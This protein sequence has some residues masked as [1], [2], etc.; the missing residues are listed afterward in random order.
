MPT[1]FGI[2][3][4]LIKRLSPSGVVRSGRRTEDIAFFERSLS[5]PKLLFI[6]SCLRAAVTLA[7]PAKISIMRYSSKLAPLVAINDAL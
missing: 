7:E 5:T 4:Q 3:S 2:C 1:T 6:P